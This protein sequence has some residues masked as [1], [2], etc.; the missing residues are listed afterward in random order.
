MSDDVWLVG[1]EDRYAFWTEKEASEVLSGLLSG[2]FLI[3]DK[4]SVV[5]LRIGLPEVVVLANG[6]GSIL[7]FLIDFSGFSLLSVWRLGFVFGFWVALS[8][9]ELSSFS[10]FPFPTIFKAIYN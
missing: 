4:S 8:N 9:E 7:I 5:N 1:D 3:G 2:E 6:V 10:C